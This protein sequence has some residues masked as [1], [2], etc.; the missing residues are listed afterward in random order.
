MVLKSKKTK[1]DGQFAPNGLLG[2]SGHKKMQTVG[3]KRE[4]VQDVTLQAVKT[5]TREGIVHYDF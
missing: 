3:R 1:A 2:T 4:S 5:Q